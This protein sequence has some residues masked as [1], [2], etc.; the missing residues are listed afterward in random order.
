MTIALSCLLAG[1]GSVYAADVFVS[2]NGDDAN[3]GTKQ[4]PLASL[5]AAKSAA[6]IFAGKEPVTVHLG[7]GT[8]YLP[9]TLTFTAKDSGTAESPV[10]YRAVN[11][12]KA[13]LSGGAKL[14]LKWEA[15]KEGIYQAKTPA[16]LEFD[17]LFVDGK[18]QH[19]A[20]YPNYD[21]SKGIRSY[22]QAA[23][24]ATSVERVKSWADPTGGFIHSMD[25]SGI[26]GHYRLITGKDS[27]GELI[28]DFEENTNIFMGFHP[29]AQFVENI[30][31]ELDAAE[32]WYHN[33]NTNRLYYKPA[34]YVDLNLAKVEVACI[35]QLIKF[36]GSEDKPVEHITL[37]GFIVRHAARTFMGTTEPILQSTWKINRSGA[38]TLTGTKSIKI[39]DTEFDGVGGNAVFVN[40][41]NRDFLIK[42]CHIHH[43]GASG[44]CFLGDP[45]GSNYPASSIVEDCLIHDIGTTEFLTSG[46]LIAMSQDITIRDCSIYDVNQL[47]ILLNEH[48]LSGHLVE[49]CDLF[50]GKR[51][52]SNRGI[53]YYSMQLNNSMSNR[54][55][56]FPKPLNNASDRPSSAIMTST[57]RNN[58]MNG[59]DR[60]LN[61]LNVNGLNYD[62]YNNWLQSGNPELSAPA[63]RCDVQNNVI[64]RKG[65]NSDEWAEFQNFSMGQFGVK[66]SSLKA[67]SKSPEMTRF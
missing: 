16:G 48:K 28:V 23:A 9:K 64:V 42:G 19:M 50:G 35:P 1:F 2:P 31:E 57:V 67:I 62:I 59:D 11:E 58:R 4:S 18:K 53:G 6:A 25:T 27:S 47:A 63:F 43:T 29:A 37:R 41:H 15:Y 52:S 40:K 30:F 61:L 56:L 55:K 36:E 46:V 49:R 22:G 14:D 5:S 60:F 66:K 65:M 21:P 45:S 13:V 10:T 26:G 38:F 24:G 54:E 39:I 44:I 20:R 32:E 8:Y 17:Q 7:D 12:G 33:S 3:T 51:M 34:E